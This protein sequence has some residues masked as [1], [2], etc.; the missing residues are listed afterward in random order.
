M[1]SMGEDDDE[2]TQDVL[3]AI[4]YSIAEFVLAY[5]DF[6]ENTQELVPFDIQ[7]AA[8]MDMPTFLETIKK[9]LKKEEDPQ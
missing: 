6:P 1:F 5:K 2:A 3:G 8:V 4:A 7:V 9:D